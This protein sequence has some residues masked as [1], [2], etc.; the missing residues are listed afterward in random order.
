METE[1]HRGNWL[2]QVYL[3]DVCV[4]GYVYSFYY[5]AVVKVNGMLCYH[6]LNCKMYTVLAVVC[7]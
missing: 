7:Y 3:D 1:N 2:T 6:Y 5:L 4:S